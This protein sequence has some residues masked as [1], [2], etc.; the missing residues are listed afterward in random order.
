MAERDALPQRSAPEEP[1]QADGDG[2]PSTVAGAL[3]TEVAEGKDP[4]HPIERMGNGA[5]TNV[6]IA[7]PGNTTR[8]E[9]LAAHGNGPRLDTR[10]ERG[11]KAAPRSH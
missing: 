5:H 7:V 9:G 8:D 10:D 11:V 6:W 2:P 1:L 3:A 4:C